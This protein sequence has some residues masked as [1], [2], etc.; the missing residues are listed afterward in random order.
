MARKRKI[1]GFARSPVEMEWPVI[2]KRMRKASDNSL[3][4]FVEFEGSWMAMSSLT[5]NR[6]QN[7]PWATRRNENVGRTIDDILKEMEDDVKIRKQVLKRGS[8][9]Y[10]CLWCGLKFAGRGPKDA[11]KHMAWNP[12]VNR[13]TCRDPEVPLDGQEYDPIPIQ[14]EEQ[15]EA[16]HEETSTITSISTL[17]K[18][19]TP[20]TTNGNNSR[21]SSRSSSGSSSG[22][23]SSSNW[24]SN[25][26][27]SPNGTSSSSTSNWSSS[28]SGSGSGS[29]RD[30]DSG[31]SNNNKSNDIRTLPSLFSHLFASHIETY[32]IIT[33]P[34]FF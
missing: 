14:E 21:G 17:P 27:S 8:K 28:I 3:Q 9:F 26:G 4:V 23:G 16:Q 15:E 6:E 20:P 12:K 5:V 25:S 2:F 34:L 11:R 10:A 32:P 13:R 33:S 1:K 24:S 29:G 30:S 18:P 31:S 19:S 7:I 22:S